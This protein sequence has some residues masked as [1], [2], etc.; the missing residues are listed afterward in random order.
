M[1]LNFEFLKIRNGLVSLAYDAQ[2][3]FGLSKPY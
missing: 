1:K 2:E 3:R